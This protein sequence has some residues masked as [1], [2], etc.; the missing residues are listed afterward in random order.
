M[1]KTGQ[2]RRRYPRAK[3]HLPVVPEESGPAL[4]NH[5]ED[6]SANGV[7]CQT[8]RP[9]PLMTRMRIGL[10]LPSPFKRRIT[11]DGVVVR[12]EPHNA[13]H[14]IY[15][16]AILFTRMDDEDHEIV[17]RFVEHELRQHS[18]PAAH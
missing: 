7:L 5:V 18:Q 14:D 3:S 13:S 6:I 4:V 10:D 15:R 8:L 17:R 12:C 9:V 11:A 1:E 2:E 16:V